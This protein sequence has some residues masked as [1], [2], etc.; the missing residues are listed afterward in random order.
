MS[1]TITYR[2]RLTKFAV[3]FGAFVCSACGIIYELALIAF[4]SYL[5]GSSITQ[6]SLVV[7]IVLSAMG[8]GALA[9]KPLLT[10]PV[11]S[12]ASVELTLGVVGAASV[13]LLYASFAW[14]DIY[15]P[16]VLTFAVLIGMLIGAE[17]P[18]L[19]ELVQMIRKQNPGSAVADL[20]AAD[21]AGALVGGIAFPF[22]LLP[23]FGLMRGAIVVGIINVIVGAWLAGWLFR[24]SMTGVERW[25]MRGLSAT[26]LGGLIVFAFAVSNLEVTARQALY[27]DPIVF[28]KRSAY[29]EI[30]LTS[31]SAVPDGTSGEDLRLY[32]NGDLQ[33]SSVDE[34]RYHEALIHPAMSGNRERVL[35]LGGGDGLALREVLRYPDVKDVTLIDIDPTIIDLAR[36]DARLSEL[37][38]DAFNDPRVHVITADAF[39]WV[40]E[41][42]DN[43]NAAD[44]DVVV[45]DFPDPDN[46]DVSKLYTVEL[47]GMTSQLIAPDGRLVIQAG[48]PY[49]APDAYWCV[50]RTVREAGFATSAYH[51]DVPSF[52]DWGYVLASKESAPVLRVDPS[53]QEHLR[54]LD[55]DVLR[56]STI[57]P[58][59]RDDRPVEPSSLLS[60][61]IVGYQ[62]QGWKD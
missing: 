25:V 60:P 7:S 47:Y 34:Y 32:L 5:V 17:I 27:D 23:I 21:Y 43:D 59:D 62:Q 31:R 30:V 54:F 29:Q 10:R 57:F 18:L 37:N 33:F 13:P 36:D 22:A 8:L 56:T 14:L 48:S 52:G 24:S 19:M 45:M 46:V 41:H 40:R 11:I 61:A 55:D 35:I 2:P 38:R 58:R 9:V 49:F 26:V 6:T 51:V 3:L 1:Q 39:T 28:S 53:V 20:S 15:T 44:F 4:G 42:N 12:F 16:A 50:V